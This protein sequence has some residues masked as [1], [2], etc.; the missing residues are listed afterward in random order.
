MEI[1]IIQIIVIIIIAALCWY[2]NATLNPIPVL[3]NVINVLI[4]VISVLALL[5]S[6]GIFS[7]DSMTIKI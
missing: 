3:K 2:A 5:G 4:V 6:L 1:N 7:S